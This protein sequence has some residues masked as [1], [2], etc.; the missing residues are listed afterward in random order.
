M[1]PSCGQYLSLLMGGV[2]ISDSELEAL[3]VRI[4]ERFGSEVRGLLVPIDAVPGYK[5]LIRE[6][7]QRGFWND[8]VGP[9][10]II[11]VFKLADGTLREFTFL[12]NNS[13]EIAR[14]CSA[15]NGD[16]LERTSD[17]PRY[18]ASNPFYREAMVACYGVPPT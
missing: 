5:E 3:G 8:L 2:D 18:L 11:F 9:E 16:P 4:L 13:D 10:Q 6:R 1:I 12:E 15:L 14:L 7:M 17:L